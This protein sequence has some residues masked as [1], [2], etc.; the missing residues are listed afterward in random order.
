MARFYPN[1]YALVL[2]CF[3]FLPCISF[4]QLQ[5]NLITSTPSTCSNNGSITVSASSPSTPILY[6]ITGGPVTAPLQTSNV[7]N[8]LPPGIYDVRV[9]DGASNSITQSVTISGNYLQPDMNPIKTS[10]YCTGGSDGQIIGNRIAGTGNGPYTWQLISPSP[11][12]TAPQVSDTFRNL[13]AGNYTLRLNDDCGGFRTVVITLSDPP[14]TNLTFQTTPH[15]NI[16]GCDSA[17]VTMYMYADLYRFPLSF[18]FVTNT[19]TFTTSSPTVVDTSGCCGFFRIEQIIPGFT[20]GNSLQVTVTDN[21][22]NVFSSPT[23][24]AKPFV[25]CPIIT[26]YFADCTTKTALD[27]NMN[28]YSCEGPGKLYT[29][30]KSPIIYSVTDLLTNVIVDAD[31]LTGFL[32]INGYY[33]VNGFTS[34]DLATNKTYN[35]AIKDGCGKTFSQQIYI[36]A[37]ATPVPP[38][39]S[40]KQLYR[41]ACLDSA[42]TA[43]ISVYNFKK[44]PQLVLLSGPSRMGSTKPGYEY[45]SIYSYPDTLEITGY[46]GLYY[47]FD[48]NNLSAGTYRFKVIDSCGSEVFDSIKILPTQVTDFNHHFTYKKGCLGRNELHYNI[49]A[50]DGYI[51]IRNISTGEETIKNYQS[52]NFNTPIHDSS[53]NLPS[54]TYEVTFVHAAYF[55]YGRPANSIVVPCQETKSTIVIEGYQTPTIIAHNYVSCKQNILL[56]IIADSSKGVPPY[57]YE[58]VSGP[59]IYPIQASKFFVINTPGTYNVRIYDVC[60]NASTSQITVSQIIFPPITALASSCNNKKLTFGS[61]P[62]YTYKWTAPNGKTFI[63]DTLNINPI[64]PADTGLYTIERITDINGCRDTSYTSYHLVSANIYERV[65]SICPGNSITIGTHTYSST[66]VYTDSL[67][68]INGCDSIVILRL[69]VLAPKRDTIYRS[70]CPGMQFLFNGKSYSTAGIYSDTLTTSGCD[71]IAT[72]VL[73]TALKQQ[74]VSLS[75]CAN[76]QYNFNGKVLTSPGIYRDT[77]PTSTCDSIITLNL[78]VLP[79]K[80]NTSYKTICAGD[81]FNFNGQIITRSGIYKDTLS[82]ASCDSIVTLNISVVSPAVQISASQQ[83]IIAGDRIQL[84]ATDALSYSWTGAGVIFNNAAIYNPGATLPAS[85]WIYLQAISNPDSCR[86]SDSIFINVI[87]RNTYCADTYIHIPTAFTPNGDGLNDVFRIVSRKIS[88]KNFMVFNRWGELVFTTN[89]LL[90]GWNGDHKGQKIPGVYV[91]YVTYTDCMGGTKLVKGTIT[92]LR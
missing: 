52:Q 81:Q 37:P 65:E 17:I 44:Q 32:A 80:Q 34:K 79:L 6:S 56:E 41:D 49:T 72:L 62:F 75:I 66:G 4:A 42:A 61:S 15:I 74:S 22:G 13:P 8:S 18:T 91:Y 1:L 73:S 19:G 45:E 46:G 89:D 55:R 21:C 71:S 29:S 59:Q 63:G 3:L 31:T 82:T 10:P 60:G 76:T 54:G 30:L 69:T 47:S 70:V 77:L 92:M 5:I 28:N 38:G 53:T 9:T 84:E 87:D 35:I 16:I 48:I 51:H 39:V 78:S 90:T 67:K 14:P 88:L 24:N 40:S 27:Y 2:L 33:Q 36:P 25:F 86:M 57:D 83:P 43:S 23:Y 12:I 26:S 58:I 11:V 7:F 64:T 85:A 68:N 20:Y 50:A